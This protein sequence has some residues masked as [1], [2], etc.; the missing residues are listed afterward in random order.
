M[1]R[2]ERCSLALLNWDRLEAVLVTPRAEYHSSSLA[3]S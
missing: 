2:K 3:T 1:K